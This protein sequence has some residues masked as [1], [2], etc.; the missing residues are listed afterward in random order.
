MRGGGL[1][2]GGTRRCQRRT[3]LGPDGPWRIAEPGPKQ[4]VEVR[5]IGEAGLQRD[6]G[7]AVWGPRAT[8]KKIHALRGLVLELCLNVPR[9]I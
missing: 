8:V 4:S 3:K 1:S 2:T 6:V 5:N 7:N 9:A